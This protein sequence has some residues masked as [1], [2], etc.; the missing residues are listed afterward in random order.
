MTSKPCRTCKDLASV[1]G[2]DVPA[3]YTVKAGDSLTAIAYRFKLCTLDPTT[4][5]GAVE[6][7]G[8]AKAIA[9]L[10]P[11]II[12]INKISVGQVI[13]LRPAPLAESHV[14]R[15]LVLAGGLGLGA[16]FLFGDGDGKR[17]A[18]QKRASGKGRRKGRALGDLGETMYD[19]LRDAEKAIDAGDCKGGLSALLSATGML[20]AE[21][22]KRGI[23]DQGGEAGRVAQKFSDACLVKGKKKWF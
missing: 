19:E 6:C 16:L 22:E 20:G 7:L 10:N 21:L 4:Q 11:A 1:I 13:R 2:D 14:L 18:P 15:N 8:I 9:A 23:A 12:D 3:S 5:E 17:P